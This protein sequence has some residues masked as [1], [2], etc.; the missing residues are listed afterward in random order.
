MCLGLLCC[1]GCAQLP[2]TVPDVE[3]RAESAEQADTALD[4]DAA[5][6]APRTD[7][8]S[9]ATYALLDAA[10]A[11]AADGDL[12]AAIALVERAIRLEPARPDLWARLG[13]LHLAQG[14]IDRAEQFA[15]KA[16]GLGGIHEPAQRPGWLLLADVRDAQGRSREAD[17]LRRRWQAT[18]EGGVG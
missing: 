13:S 17:L 15:R 6:T 7:R 10:G 11:Q 5:P 3:D 8:S 18:A 2:E 16:I 4:P 1:A 9:G 12:D 14:D